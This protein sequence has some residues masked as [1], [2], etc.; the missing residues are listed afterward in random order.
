MNTH[1]HF[2]AIESTYA[3][4]SGEHVH[5]SVSGPKDALTE[6]IFPLLAT[7]IYGGRELL[8]DT[9]HEDISALITDIS[10]P[11]D[12]N[13]PLPGAPSAGV[14]TH[15]ITANIT[16]TEGRLDRFW[17]PY[18]FANLGHKRAA[19]DAEWNRLVLDSAWAWLALKLPSLGVD[20]GLIYVGDNINTILRL[21]AS[22]DAS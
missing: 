5:L 3:D 8:R 1:I 9:T 15:T 13:I 20:V 17:M 4:E 16:L 12:N 19:Q 7:A 11:I 14:G 21:K 22:F 6:S 2:I 18:D 10:K